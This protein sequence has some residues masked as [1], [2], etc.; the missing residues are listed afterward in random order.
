MKKNYLILLSVL[1][2]CFVS[3]LSSS[4]V[5]AQ[6]AT[7]SI[8]PPVVEILLAP[9]KKL[10]QTFNLEYTGEATNIIPEL[11]LA[12]P[13]GDQG[14]VT[15]DPLPLAPSSISLV[16]NSS[17]PLNQPIL[18]KDKV[19]RITLT[20]E[21]ATTDIP[22]DTYLALVLK[23]VSPID[24]SK[25]TMTSP[26][27]SSLILT[28]VNPSGITPINLEVGHFTLPLFHDSYLPLTIT[29]TLTNHVPIMV[30][31]EGKYEIIS[32]SG[33]TIYSL[34]LYPSLILGESSRLLTGEKGPLTWTPTWTNFGP[35]RL[36]LTITTQ[37][38]S[39]ITEVEKVI[40]ILPIRGI[41]LV[42][43]L[44]I[45]WLTIFIL[46]KRNQIKKSLDT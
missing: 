34:P 10:T 25:S 42:L 46:K 8:S 4:P 35:H 26:G 45:F 13:E 33:K 23:A 36:K 12:H 38:G 27:I 6:T 2:C 19:L 17:P 22:I 39:K 3:L 5:H 30:R 37:G 41:I 29:P 40:W 1:V 28:T 7:M 9:N 15:L 44:L 11:H 21:A 24:G 32:P 20:I 43:L 18:I 31:P 16:I 14:H